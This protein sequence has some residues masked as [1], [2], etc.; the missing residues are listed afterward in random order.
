MPD[1][2]ITKRWKR[3]NRPNKGAGTEA[4]RQAHNDAVRKARARI[5]DNM[6]FDDSMMGK[7]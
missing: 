4:K 2:R 1:K 5:Y 7:R 6:L 3:E